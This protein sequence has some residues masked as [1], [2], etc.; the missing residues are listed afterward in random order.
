MVRCELKKAHEKYTCLKEIGLH[1]QN[2]LTSVGSI[3]NIIG[4][5]Y[6]SIHTSSKKN[7]ENGYGL[8]LD[9]LII[10]Y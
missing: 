6:M 7:E 10:S 3:V 9:S 4:G 5:A 2:L 8:N 1:T